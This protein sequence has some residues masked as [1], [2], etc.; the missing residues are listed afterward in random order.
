[1]R[2]LGYDY[3]HYS[4]MTNVDRWFVAKKR[5]SEI[6]YN[7]PN[8]LAS[9]APEFTVDKATAITKSKTLVKEWFQVASGSAI[10]VVSVI[11]NNPE[12][13]ASTLSA[14]KADISQFV[15]AEYVGLFITI[16]GFVGIYIR[17]ITNKDIQHKIDYER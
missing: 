6:I 15:G 2:D 8:D 5:A 12:A 10:S 14:N 9:D 17:T 3:K 11:K 4:K 16:L 7:T 1:M 13:V